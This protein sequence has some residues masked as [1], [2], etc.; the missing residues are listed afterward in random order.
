MTISTFETL[1]KY[2]RLYLPDKGMVGTFP[3]LAGVLSRP[4]RWDLIAQQYDEMVS[5]PSP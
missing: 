2:E 1:P 5:M 3:N 4:I